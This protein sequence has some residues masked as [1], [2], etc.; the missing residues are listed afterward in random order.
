MF[1]TKMFLGH[2][3]YLQSNRAELSIYLF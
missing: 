1:E 2:Q 3:Q